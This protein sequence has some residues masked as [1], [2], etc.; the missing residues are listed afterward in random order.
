MFL[1]NQAPISCGAIAMEQLP[2]VVPYFDTIAPI[3]TQAIYRAF[4][5]FGPSIC[6]KAV[7]VFRGQYACHGCLLKRS[8]TDR[9]RRHADV[10]LYVDPLDI[11]YRHN[12]AFLKLP[13]DTGVP[14]RF[15]FIHEPG[16]A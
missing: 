5:L 3:E 15:I 7:F 8:T 12:G 4:S 2:L 1:Q 14:R 9:E 10:K 16:G 6:G 11:E 13:Q